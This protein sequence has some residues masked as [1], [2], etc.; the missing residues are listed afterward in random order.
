MQQHN[1]TREVFYACLSA[2]V[3]PVVVLWTINTIAQKKRCCQKSV[4]AW[5]NWYQNEVDEEIK[6][7]DSRDN[8]KQTE[9]S[10]Q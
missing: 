7:T 5:R 8:V 1:R 4:N 6:G 9:R 10:D 2:Q 3:K